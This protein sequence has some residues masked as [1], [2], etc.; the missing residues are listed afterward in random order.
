MQIIDIDNSLYNVPLK[1]IFKEAGKG[2][3]HW[4]TL[5]AMACKTLEGLGYG[6]KSTCHNKALEVRIRMDMQIWRITLP[7]QQ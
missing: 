6:R 7:W 2:I 5:I 3:S 1:N 4:H